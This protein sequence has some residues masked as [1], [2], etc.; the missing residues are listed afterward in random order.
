MVRAA[1]IL[2]NVIS[3]GLGPDLQ[4]MLV[5]SKCQPLP[6]KLQWYQ[7]RKASTTVTGE[8]LWRGKAFLFFNLIHKNKVSMSCIVS[9]TTQQAKHQNPG[10]LPFTL[11][12]EPQTCTWLL[13]SSTWGI[14]LLHTWAQKSQAFMAQDACIHWA[15][16]VHFIL[17]VQHQ[18]SKKSSNY[19]APTL[20]QASHF[21]I[22][23]LDM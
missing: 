23:F 21:L 17:P 10:Q 7:C 13:L 22:I 6:W 9:R 14:F 4:R 12:W 3:A 2:V 15:F 1:P 11:Q 8:K 16:S 18:F 20:K 19:W 5:A